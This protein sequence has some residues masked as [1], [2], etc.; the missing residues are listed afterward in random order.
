M[1]SA[2]QELEEVVQSPFLK[3]TCGSLAHGI[4]EVD[5]PDDFR[6]FL[7]VYQLPL[8]YLIQFLRRPRLLTL[9]EWEVTMSSRKPARLRRMPAEAPSA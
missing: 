5:G 6:Q 7:K 3:A 2:I 9:I 1:Q 8:R 4:Q